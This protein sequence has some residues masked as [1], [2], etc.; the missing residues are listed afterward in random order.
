MD[1]WI[2]LHKDLLKFSLNIITFLHD[3]YM[4]LVNCLIVWGL[5]VS[6]FVLWKL[7]WSSCWC[8][9]VEWKYQADSST[10]IIC[11]RTYIKGLEHVTL[12]TRIDSGAKIWKFFHTWTTKLSIISVPSLPPTFLW[13]EIM[14]GWKTWIES[15]LHEFDA[16]S[17]LE[18]DTYKAC[19]IQGFGG[20]FGASKQKWVRKQANK[21]KQ[22]HRHNWGMVHWRA[23]AVDRESHYSCQSNFFS[24][25][26]CGF[27]AWNDG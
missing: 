2:N 23:E 20:E 12:L 27:L 24:S 16:A 7:A 5:N 21:Q 6:C 3:N 17:F 25:Y 15:N 1:S 10:W 14:Q 18:Y 4:F 11:T 8:F 9:K 26:F 13:E 22:F 19:C